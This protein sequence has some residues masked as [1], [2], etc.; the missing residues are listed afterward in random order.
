MCAIDWAACPTCLFVFP[1]RLVQC[2]CC[3]ATPPNIGGR[4]VQTGPTRDLLW[5]DLWFGDTISRAIVF[6][7]VAHEYGDGFAAYLVKQLDARLEAVALELAAEQDMRE[8]KAAT[9]H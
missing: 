6:A 9:I 8:A 1:R 7:A 5:S 2:Q 3:G 4:L